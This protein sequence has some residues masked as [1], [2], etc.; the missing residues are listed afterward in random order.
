MTTK[1]EIENKPVAIVQMY[2][3]AQHVA[4]KIGKSGILSDIGQEDLFKQIAYKAVPMKYVCI[5]HGVDACEIANMVRIRLCSEMSIIGGEFIERV[6]NVVYRY[7]S[8]LVMEVR[9]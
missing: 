3:V 5:S 2:D 4:D 9:Q 1:I 8:A 7:L 6:Y